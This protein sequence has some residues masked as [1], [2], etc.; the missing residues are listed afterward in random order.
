MS[1]DQDRK[2]LK[3][4]QERLFKAYSLSVEKQQQWHKQIKE[5]E[6]QANTLKIKL[7]IKF[8]RD[9]VDEIISRVVHEVAEKSQ[10][11]YGNNKIYEFL[12]DNPELKKLWECDYLIDVA[13]RLEDIDYVERCMDKYKKNMLEVDNVYAN[14]K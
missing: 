6:N 8:D 11:N 13:Y 4:L 14:T 1:Q 9:K 5:L 12:D 2:Q 3:L 10:G 7:N